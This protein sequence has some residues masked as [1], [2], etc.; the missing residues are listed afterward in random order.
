MFNR[1]IT[2]LAVLK[3]ANA[4]GQRETVIKDHLKAAK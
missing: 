3:G 2:D 1:E 4:A